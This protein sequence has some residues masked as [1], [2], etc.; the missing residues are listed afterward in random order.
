M[1]AAILA[2]KSPNNGRRMTCDIFV[3]DHLFLPLLDKKL[4]RDSATA[5]KLT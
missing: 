2:Q 5:T 1:L 3:T 4:Q